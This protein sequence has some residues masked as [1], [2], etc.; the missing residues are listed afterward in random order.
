MGRGARP[1][2]GRNIRLCARAKTIPTRVSRLGLVPARRAPG[3]SPGPWAG[4]RTGE[5][6]AGTDDAQDHPDHDR[7]ATG[8]KEQDTGRPDRRSAPGE[9]LVGDDPRECDGSHDQTAGQHPAS[10]LLK[11]VCLEH[12][13]YRAATE[14]PG[15]WGSSP[16]DHPGQSRA[17]SMQSEL[18]GRASRRATGI[19]SPHRSHTP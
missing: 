17:H 15:L 14:H 4:H 16:R 8:P 12:R 13:P 10:Q 7:R 3:P 5:S 1:R 2:C 18:A 11:L 19:S 6:G 9:H